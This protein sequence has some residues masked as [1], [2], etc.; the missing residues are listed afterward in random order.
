MAE[1]PIMC[2][3]SSGGVVARLEEFKGLFAEG[4]TGVER[5]PLRL[6]LIF[7]ADAAREAVVRE[8]FAREERCCAFLEF[9]YGRAEGGLVV[10]VSAPDG[11]GATLDGMQALA[12]RNASPE[13]VA[14]GWAR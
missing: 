1:V 5:E 2:A 14:R 6:R 8:L 10:E 3:L 12:E 7:D 4:L 13:D 11:A 9:G